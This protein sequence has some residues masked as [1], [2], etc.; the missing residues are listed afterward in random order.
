[1][2]VSLPVQGQQKN[3]LATPEQVAEFM[4]VSRSMIYS[5]MAEGTLPFCRVG[6]L[7]RI[8]W[9]EVEAYL[10]SQSA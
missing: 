3:G 8:R 5:M 6:R 10:K 1:M 4:Q 2:T 9:P 7:R